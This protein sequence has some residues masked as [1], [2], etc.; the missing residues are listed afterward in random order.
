MKQLCCIFLC[1]YF[2]K[3]F[4]QE[5]LISHL[6][7]LITQWHYAA[8]KAD[9]KAYFDA[10]DENAVFIGTDSTEY[11]TKEQFYQ[12]AKPYFDKGKAWTLKANSRHIYLS[13]N[14]KT[15]WWDELLYTPS[16]TWIGT[17][18]LVKKGKAWKI[19]HYTLSVTIPNEKLKDIVKILKID[20]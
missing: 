16:G 17:G 2:G 6:D 8:A 4:A 13:D 19:I 20:R 3:I 12:W 18:I 10:M 14:K 5:N 7:S 15:A 11:W 9:M 1:F